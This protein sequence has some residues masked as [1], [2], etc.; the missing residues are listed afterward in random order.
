MFFGDIARSYGDVVE[1]YA[2]ISFEVTFNPDVFE[3][4][5][6]DLPE[7]IFERRKAWSMRDI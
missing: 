4:S 6:A 7:D 2:N 3:Y 1:D 5:V